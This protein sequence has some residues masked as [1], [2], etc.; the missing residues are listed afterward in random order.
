MMKVFEKM[1]NTRLV[2]FLEKDGQFSSVQCGFHRPRSTLDALLRLE[3]TICQDFAS[4]QRVVS[5][6]F[7]LEKAHDSPYGWTQESPPSVP[8]V[9]FTGPYF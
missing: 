2:R 3:K 4:R 8:P 6:F 9:F 7:D 1:V 5:V